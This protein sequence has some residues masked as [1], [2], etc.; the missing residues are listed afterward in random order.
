MSPDI[1]R[2][3]PQLGDVEGDKLL[4]L[5][6]VAQGDVVHVLGQVH[7]EEARDVDEDAEEDDGEDEL[8]EAEAGGVVLL[9]QAVAVGLADSSVPAHNP[10]N[11]FSRTFCED[12]HILV[13]SL[14]HET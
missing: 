10:L 11:Q 8:E 1:V 14:F 5:G 4:E 9:P 6:G 13:S 12:I 3:H 2:V 7:L